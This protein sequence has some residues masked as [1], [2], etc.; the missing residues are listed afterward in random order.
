MYIHTYDFMFQHPLYYINIKNEICM[1]IYRHDKFACN[2]NSGT[3][4]ERIF[5]CYKKDKSGNPI[6][7]ITVIFPGK[8]FYVYICTNMN[9][10]VHLFIDLC[11]CI[12][13]Y[14][15][16]YLYT[17]IYIYICIYIYVYIHAYV[18]MYIYTYIYIRMY[19]CIYI[20][21]IHENI[22]IICTHTYIF[23]SYIH[24]NILEF[25]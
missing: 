2:L 24:I 8:F 25:I 23:I 1:F 17:Y 7:D 11:I 13:K 15:C 9:L 5:L 18:Y 3:S 10:F 4:S 20:L 16:V 22:Y 19:V 6:T 21:N 12:C 14:I